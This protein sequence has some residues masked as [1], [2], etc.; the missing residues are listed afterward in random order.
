MNKLLPVFVAFIGGA[1]I[2][3]VIV[4]FSKPGVPPADLRL[5][6]LSRRSAVRYPL[7]SQLEHTSTTVKNG[8]RIAVF[9]RASSTGTYLRLENLNGG[10]TYCGLTAASTSV[11]TTNGIKL[12]NPNSTSP[13]SKSF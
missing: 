13:G 5:L 11:G 10:D 12:A 7:F 6:P 1:V 9:R 2:G 3:L 8:S 4:L